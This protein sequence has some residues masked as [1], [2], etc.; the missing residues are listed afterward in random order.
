MV[1]TL[2]Q[3]M[4]FNAIKATA[5]PRNEYERTKNLFDGSVEH[6]RKTN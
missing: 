6:A 3:G 4:P 1:M 5:N 2:L